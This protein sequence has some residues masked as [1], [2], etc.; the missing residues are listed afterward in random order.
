MDKLQEELSDRTPL[1]RSWTSEYDYNETIGKHAIE[2]KQK[3]CYKLDELPKHKLTECPNW[4]KGHEFAVRTK[5][6]KLD[7]DINLT[8]KEWDREYGDGKIFYP[9]DGSRGY[10]VPKTTKIFKISNWEEALEKF[11]VEVE[12]NHG[13]NNLYIELTAL[14]DE[15]WGRQ[16][17]KDGRRV[18]NRYY[19][20]EWVKTGSEE[21]IQAFTRKDCVEIYFRQ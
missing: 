5:I 1:V 3:N 13:N 4:L 19:Y 16:K 18:G 11:W 14:G 2:V 9:Y 15:D 12:L 10:E 21:I 20:G 7:R 8:N 6:Y 17:Y